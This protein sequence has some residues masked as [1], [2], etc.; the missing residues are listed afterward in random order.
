[1]ILVFVA[2]RSMQTFYFLFKY[3]IASF[4]PCLLSNLCIYL[5]AKFVKESTPK[6]TPERGVG[7]DWKQNLELSH[8][9]KESIL[10]SSKSH[11]N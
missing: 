4:L 3:F 6:N 9:P 1:M 2:S 7:V 11:L 8:Q 10:Y 5:N